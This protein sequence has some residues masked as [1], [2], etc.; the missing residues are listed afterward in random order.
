MFTQVGLIVVALTAAAPVTTDTSFPVSEI[1][2]F[3]KTLRDGSTL[4]LERL[5]FAEITTRYFAIPED[6]LDGQRPAEVKETVVLCRLVKVKGT[7]R[8]TVWETRLAIDA[9]AALSP[10]FVVK[11]AECVNGRLYLL[12][13]FNGGF[14]EMTTLSHDTTGGWRNVNHIRLDD[15]RRAWQE[16]RLVEDSQG[17]AV[18]CIDRH[19]VNAA[20]EK[21]DVRDDGTLRKRLAPSPPR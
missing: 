6:K 19:R 13:A 20:E 18:A 21:W 7:Q 8:E 4:L 5:R 2:P 14:L 3:S 1:L 10:H 16:C 11:D 9:P 15:R 12:Y 17:L